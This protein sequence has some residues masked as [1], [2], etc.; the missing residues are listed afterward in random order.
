MR[1]VMMSGA[2][3]PVDFA[4]EARDLKQALAANAY[5]AADGTAD[6]DNHAVPIIE[7]TLR[8]IVARA[9]RDSVQPTARPFFECP[10]C[11]KD[12]ADEDEPHATD[13][14]R[15]AT[16]SFDATARM[17]EGPWQLQIG[18]PGSG[19]WDR[20]TI[21]YG[22]PGQGL[23]VCTVNK[24]APKAADLARALVNAA[25]ALATPQP[26]A[27]PDREA[28]EAALKIVG[29]PASG[30][31]MMS[32]RRE[33][34]AVH[35]LLSAALAT[36]QPN[37]RGRWRHLKRGSTYTE[38]GRGKM[39]AFESCLDMEDVVIYR[40]DSDGALWVRPTNEFEDGR[41]EAID[42]NQQSERTR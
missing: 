12:I 34:M 17:V 11:G 27:R 29:D 5:P 22:E 36:Q 30:N 15:A 28:I 26:T 38:I 13:C 16:A 9:L 3:D 40:A 42:S 4:K 24:M 18:L 35:K 6:I 23:V 31:K 41:F 2:S 7:V 14:S 37:Q 8:N 39:Q 32:S 33:A 1:S 10:D 19:P 21:E 20:I 25:N